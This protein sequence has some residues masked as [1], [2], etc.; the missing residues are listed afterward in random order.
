MKKIV[1]HALLVCAGCLF[2]LKTLAQPLP[3]E[4]RA[5]LPVATLAGQAKLT[6]WGFAVYQATLWVTTGFDGTAY[7]HNAFALE[8]AYFRDFTGADIASRSMTEMRHQAPI[9]AAQE[10]SWES[11]MRA[12]FPDV[13]TGDRI[14]GVHQPGIGA[15]FWSNGRLLGEVRDPTFAKL[16]FGIWLSPKTSEPQLRLALLAQAP[17]LAR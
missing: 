13:K 4:L 11:Q 1:A 5:S 2:C 17:A 9:T 16:F 3:A 6:F 8:L 14:T 15:V 12:M 7:E 10:A